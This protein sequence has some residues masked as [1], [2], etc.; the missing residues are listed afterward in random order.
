MLP[1]NS[2]GSCFFQL[3]RPTSPGYCLIAFAS[4]DQKSLDTGKQMT[5]VYLYGCIWLLLQAPSKTFTRA[6]NKTI[7]Q[8]YKSLL[9]IVV[10][11]FF[12]S[13][14]NLV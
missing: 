1:W 13:Y 7:K 3:C 10:R 12:L 5:H 8:T 6:L 4:C 11:C 2:I 9:K 14:N